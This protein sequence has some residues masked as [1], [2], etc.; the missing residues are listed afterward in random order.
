MKK[1]VY[2][3]NVDWYFNLHWLDRALFFKSHG[4]D[5]YIIS[6]FKTLGL[7]DEM[8]SLGFECIP[9]SMNRSSVNVLGEFSYIVS[10][11][12]I[13]KKIEPDLIHAVTIKPNVYAGLI[14]K[15]FIKKPIIYSVTGLGAIFSSKQIK[16]YFLKK[17]VVLLYKFVSLPTSRFI[18]E[19]GEDIDTFTSLRILRGNG[20]TIR[21]AGIDLAL[22]SPSPP[23]AKKIVLFAARLL[24]DKGLCFLIEAKQL[25]ESQGVE[26]TLNVAG[27]IDDDVSS[28]ISINQVEHWDKNGDINWLGNVKDMPKLIKESDIVCLPTTYGEGVPRIL[29]EAASC[30]RAII[31]TDVVGCREIVSHNI[32]GLLVQPGDVA[33]LAKSLQSLLD[34]DQKS[35][36]F[37][38]LGRKK[39]EEEFSQEIVFEKTLQVYEELSSTR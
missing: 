30:Q 16:F 11:C 19:N 13:L 25:L 1:I 14:N 37:G 35:L 27:I 9:L 39:V 29:I 36:R 31:T 5:I 32:N 10:L 22:F 17:I 24:K 6:D 23:P 8:S 18:F 26:F 7:I 20:L 12:R 3:I 15:F 4:Y 28:A 33:S 2:V 34:D 38:L 21:G